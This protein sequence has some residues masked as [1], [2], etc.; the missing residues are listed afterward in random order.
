MVGNWGLLAVE[1]PALG[2][3]PQ[4]E[5]CLKGAIAA[6]T[7]SLS[8]GRTLTSEGGTGPRRHF[9]CGSPQPWSS[10][11]AVCSGAGPSW[12]G[13]LRDARPEGLPYWADGQHDAWKEEEGGGRA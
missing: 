13:L 3:T 11:R 10:G 2:L 7:G 1:A 9:C 6:Q 12:A 5:E 4:P 8:P